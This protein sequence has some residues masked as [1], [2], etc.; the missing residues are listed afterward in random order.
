MS[1][2]L[3]ALQAQVARR[4]L[5][6]EG[7]KRRHVVVSLSGAHAYGFPSPDSDLDLKCV[8]A[9]PTARLL[10]LRPPP[11]HA[12]RMEFIDGV[13]IDYSTNEL[14]GVLSAIVQGNGNYFER[15]LGAVPLE[16]SPAAGELRPLL[17]R[18]LSKRIH[19]HYAGFARG[20]LHEWERSGFRSAKKLLYVLRTALTGTHVLLAAEIETDL[21]RLAPRYGFGEAEELIDAKRRG[22]KIELAPEVAERWKAGVGR[23][24]EA[25]GR[26]LLESPL[27][28]DPPN[29]DE[30]DAW[31]V[32]FRQAPVAGR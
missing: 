14:G 26:A 8:H 23:A 11:P 2:V 29:V 1:E 21:G 24:L 10:G 4:V 7:A 3:T 16:E 28:E 5:A 31:L 12:S 15:F 20:Q 22:E 19:R 18:A 9:E 6:E 13:E 27:P 32:A 17:R 25:L 30:L